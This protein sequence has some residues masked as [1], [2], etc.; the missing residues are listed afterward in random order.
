MF[1]EWDVTAD[2]CVTVDVH[3]VPGKKT[4]LIIRGQNFNPHQLGSPGRQDLQ[5]G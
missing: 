4:I 5:D 2:F 3:G 1:S